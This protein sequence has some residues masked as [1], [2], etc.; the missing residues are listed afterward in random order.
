MPFAFAVSMA[1]SSRVASSKYVRPRSF[2]YEVHVAAEPLANWGR[3]L[4]GAAL[5]GFVG[6]IL[7]STLLALPF[8]WASS[9]SLSFNLAGALFALAVVGGGLRGLAQGPK[10]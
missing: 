10:R 3:M 9:S 2:G 8:R 4:V 7:W 1:L 5:G 6:L